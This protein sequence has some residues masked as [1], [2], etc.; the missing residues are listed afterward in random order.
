MSWKKKVAVQQ[1]DITDADVDAIVNA[2]KG[3]WGGDYI[4]SK[5]GV[6]VN[7]SQIIP[8]EGVECLVEKEGWGSYRVRVGRKSWAATPPTVNTFTDE[9]TC[10]EENVGEILGDDTAHELRNEGQVAVYVTII[11]TLQ[12]NNHSAQRTVISVFGI[13]DPVQPLALSTCLALR[14]MGIELWMCT[15]DHEVTAHAIARKIGIEDDHVCAAIRPEGKADLVTR[16]QK[17]KE[18]HDAVRK[19]PKTLGRQRKRHVVAMVGDGINDAV[20]LARADVGIAIGAGTEVAVEAADIVLVKNCLH[21][22]VIALHLSRTVFN[23]IRWNFVWAMGYNVCALPFAAGILYP[24]IDWKLPPAFA[25]LMMAFSSVSVVTSSLLLRF[26]RKPLIH[27]DGFI[28]ERKAWYR[29]FC[30]SLEQEEHEDLVVMGPAKAYDFSGNGE[31]QF[32]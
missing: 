13:V 26:Y 25:G 5:K 8:G 14:R 30:P 19:G 17:R 28:E 10:T 6:C 12:E 20:A 7:E 1:G 32:A 24:F 3:I 16:L 27:N 31:Y 2:A 18:N 9:V 22:V 23:R 11:P 4:C 15:G 21:D 29:L